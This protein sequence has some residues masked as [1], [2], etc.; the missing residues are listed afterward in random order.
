MDDVTNAAEF[1]ASDL[2]AGQHLLVSGGARPD[3]TPASNDTIEQLIPK[4]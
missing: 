3:S 1:F 2:S 4:A